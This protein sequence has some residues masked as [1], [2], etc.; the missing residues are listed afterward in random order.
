MS[1]ILCMTVLGVLLMLLA[2]TSSYLRW[3]PVTTSAVCLAFGA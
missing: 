1:F 3:L 2:L